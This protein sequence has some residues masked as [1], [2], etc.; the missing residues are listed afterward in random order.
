M[1]VNETFFFFF[2]GKKIKSRLTYLL[3]PQALRNLLPASFASLLCSGTWFRADLSC[4]VCFT[5]LHPDRLNSDGNNSRRARPTW[6]STCI[7]AGLQSSA[8]S[9]RLHLALKSHPLPH[10]GCAN[11]AS[12]SWK[13]FL[14]SW[15]SPW[16]TSTWIPPGAGLS[17]RVNLHLLLPWRRLLVGFMVLV[18]H[19]NWRKAVICSWC[20]A[21][22]KCRM[23]ENK[24]RPAGA[25]LGVSAT[26]HI[27]LVFIF[28]IEKGF[29]VPESGGDCLKYCW[30]L[31]HYLPVSVNLSFSFL[32]M[33]AKHPVNPLF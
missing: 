33:G 14:G 28:I 6:E 5:P 12:S 10:K 32:S 30:Y 21:L 29:F 18:P 15:F 24:K 2:F 19:R 22:Y 25:E 17:C 20:K 23:Q 13:H 8:L 27:F 7:S 11:Y 16:E 9:P 4:H 1:I 26:T 3:L 31:L